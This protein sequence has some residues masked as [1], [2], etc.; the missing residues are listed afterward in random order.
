M[1]TRPQMA[2]AASVVFAVGAAVWVL[3]KKESDRASMRIAVNKDKERIKEY[4]KNQQAADNN[5]PQ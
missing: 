5:K 1:P 4:Y 3:Q 2:I